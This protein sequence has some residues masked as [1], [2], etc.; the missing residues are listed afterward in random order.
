[1]KIKTEWEK[2]VEKVRFWY[3][4]TANR[5]LN[6]KTRFSQ[7]M[8][9]VEMLFAACAL[10]CVKEVKAIKFKLCENE[11]VKLWLM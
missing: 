8:N 11:C 7:I 5:N 4:R 2:E 1:M 3:E 10:C 6:H 9:Y